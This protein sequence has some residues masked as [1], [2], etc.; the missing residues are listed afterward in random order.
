VVKLNPGIF[1]MSIDVNALVKKLL[2]KW[3]FSL[4]NITTRI[5]YKKGFL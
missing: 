1:G 2:R 3:V 5:V 4:K